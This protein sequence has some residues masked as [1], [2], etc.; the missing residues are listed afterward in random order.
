[1]PHATDRP[2]AT[3]RHRPPIRPWI[4]AVAD[5][6]FSLHVYELPSLPKAWAELLAQEPPP[7]Y[8]QLLSQRVIG[9]AQR[10]AQGYVVWSASDAGVLYPR[11]DPGRALC[12]ILD[13]TG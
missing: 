3:G 11:H 2:P 12:S 8:P 7:Q 9:H 1:M 10:V 4:R 6:G 13:F 5:D